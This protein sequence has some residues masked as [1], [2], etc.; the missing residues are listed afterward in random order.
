M[1]CID[2]VERA[3]SISTKANINH[4]QN[5]IENTKAALQDSESDVIRLGAETGL[6]VEDARARVAA[7]RVILTHWP[8]EYWILSNFQAN[9]ISFVKLPSNEY[10]RNLL[11]ISQHWFR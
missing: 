1:A 9:L 7:L 3:L 10:Y 5:T 8:L 6:V 11:M 2:S 4:L